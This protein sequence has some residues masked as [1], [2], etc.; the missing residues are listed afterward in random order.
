MTRIVLIAFILTVGLTHITAG[1][2]AVVRDPYKQRQL[3][4][5]VFMRWGG[6]KPKW[7]YFLFHNKYRKGPDRRTILQLL[8]TDA[9]IR[10]NKEKSEDEADEVVEMYAMQYYDAANRGLELHY[11]FHFKQIFDVLNEEIDEL[12]NQAI[13]LNTEPKAVQSFTKEQERL[14]NEIEIIRQ[15][16]LEKGDSVEAMKEI[17]NDLRTLK[18]NLIKFVKLQNI[19]QKYSAIQP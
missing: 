19:N 5:M 10:L 16:W 13:E 17:E 11:H 3:E 14:N 7:Y 1:Q 12:R 15:G 4:N 2:V 9:V 6:F 8:P 18:G